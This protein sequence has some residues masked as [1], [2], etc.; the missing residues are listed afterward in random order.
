MRKSVLFFVLFVSMALAATAF[1][2]TA[3]Q[4]EKKPAA[5]KAV[6]AAPVEQKKAVEKEAK[7]VKPT[8]EKK[9][10]K[11]PVAKPAKAAF[12]TP[13]VT[14]ESFEVPQYDGWWFFASKV[15][16]TKGDK[17]DRGA[18]LPMSFLF[19]VKNPNKFPIALDGVKFTVA[20]DRE[21]EV[22]T[23][24]NNDVMWIPPG[25]TNHFRATTMITARS[26]QLSLLVTGGY[27]LK[28]KGWDVWAALERWWKGVPDAT[29]PVTVKEGAFSFTGNGMTKV[30]PFDA[31]LQ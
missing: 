11:A 23:Y 20:F 26:A 27:K 4:P 15:E 21:F 9:V 24:N 19:S 3:A 7:A 6:K 8:E 10:A 1:G 14:L 5:E 29:V 31:T 13:I 12:I 28:E 25:K 22:V 2:Q 16:P 18:P 17:G 30:I